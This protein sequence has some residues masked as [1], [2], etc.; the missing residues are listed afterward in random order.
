MHEVPGSILKHCQKNKNKEEV[1]NAYK[2]PRSLCI[3]SSVI[4]T[5][6][7]DKEGKERRQKNGPGWSAWLCKWREKVGWLDENPISL[8]GEIL[9]SSLFYW[10]AL[11]HLKNAAWSL[12]AWQTSLTISRKKIHH[13]FNRNKKIN[14]H[15]FL[16]LESW[17][18]S[19]QNHFFWAILPLPSPQ[20]ASIKAEHKMVEGGA[21]S[22]IW[23]RPRIFYKNKGSGWDASTILGIETKP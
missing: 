13:L 7:F 17:R 22:P 16:S 23:Q 6:K 14:W 15:L 12:Q 20:K 1:S 10:L 3:H 11:F 21:Y 9:L 4:T 19:P 2:L 18:E 5:R 8:S